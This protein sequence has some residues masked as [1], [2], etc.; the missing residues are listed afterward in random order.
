[1]EGEDQMNKWRGTQNV[2]PKMRHGKLIE[3]DGI[4]GDKNRKKAGER[5][6]RPLCGIEEG[7]WEKGGPGIFDRGKSK[8]LS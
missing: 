3:E 1:L 4:G 7:M 6:A 8:P 2:H 5:G